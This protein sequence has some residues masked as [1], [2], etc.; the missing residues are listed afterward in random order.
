MYHDHVEPEESKNLISCTVDVGK[1]ES[2]E[3]QALAYIQL[4]K[5]MENKFLLEIKKELFALLQE[6]KDMFWTKMV[7]DT[8]AKHDGMV[9]K[10]K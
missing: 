3:T 1:T 10:R 8:P 6:F 7:V 2:S 9:V 4:D 5:M